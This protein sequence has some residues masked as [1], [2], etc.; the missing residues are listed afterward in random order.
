MENGSHRVFDFAMEILDALTLSQKQDTVF[1]KL[2]FAANLKVAVGP[3]SRILKM[4]FIVF[5]MHTKTTL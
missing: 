4:D 2:K 3:C 1:E 5:T